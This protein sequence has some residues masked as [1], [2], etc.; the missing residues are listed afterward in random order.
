MLASL[1]IRVATHE[2]LPALHPVIERAY[3]GE[4]ARAGWTHEADLVG[5]NRTDIPTLAGIVDDPGQRLLVA[6]QGGTIIGCV[7]VSDKGDGLAYLGLLCIDPTLQAGGHGKQ[8]VAAA[9]ACAREDFAARRME[10]T[11]I[12][13]RRR[14]IAFYE[15]RG[16]V[17]SGEKRDFPIPLDPPLFMDVLVKDL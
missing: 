12:D 10:M 5:G 3:R 2:D 9:E 8:L 15:R 11:V 14:L 13:V 7:Q 17:V 6:L 1:T 16:Y 4:S